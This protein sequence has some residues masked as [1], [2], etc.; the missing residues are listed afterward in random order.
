MALSN[1][2]AYCNAATIAAVKS[3][4]VQALGGEKE[5]SI[6]TFNFELGA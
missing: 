6:R 3:F 5:K 1:A 4:I 2:L